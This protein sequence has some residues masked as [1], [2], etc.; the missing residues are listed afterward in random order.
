M[1]IQSTGE[2]PN[3]G[4]RRDKYCKTRQIQGA[5]KIINRWWFGL[6]FARPAKDEES[7]RRGE[8]GILPGTRAGIVKRGRAEGVAEIVREHNRGIF[9]LFALKTMGR[10]ATF[11]PVCRSILVGCS[12][13]KH[14]H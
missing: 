5:G 11:V 4:E 6:G 2:A 9:L 3:K 10:Q 14:H 1:Q 12:R 8:A 7:Y 13:A